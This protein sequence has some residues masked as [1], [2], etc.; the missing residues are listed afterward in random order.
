MYPFWEVPHLT[1]GLIIAMIA[2]FHILPSHLATGAFWFMAYIEGKAIND[3]RP[4]LFAFLKRFSLFILVFCFVIGSLTGVG[5]WFSATVASPRA[6]SGLIHNYVW[7]WA[8][9]WVFFLIE[10]ATIYAYYYTFGKVPPRTHRR[11]GLI[12]AWGAWMSMV[13][14]TGILGFMLSSD[15]WIE[16][17]SFFDGFFNSTYWPQLAFRTAGMIAIASVYAIIVAASLEKGKVRYEVIRKAGAWGLCALAA[18]ALF[19]AWYLNALPDHSKELIFQDVIPPLK[20]MLHV[21]IGAAVAVAV[22]FLLF[23]VVRPQLAC[24]SFG[25]VMM[26]VLLAGIGA[27]EGLREGCRRPYI[28]N[29]YM[30]GNQVVARD[31]EAKKVKGEVEFFQE[32]GLTSRLL[33]FPDQLRIFPEEHLAKAG[34]IIALHQCGNCHTMDQKG[35]RPLPGLLANLGLEDAESIADFLDAL[36]EYPFMP[37]FAAD[38]DEKRATAAYL[39]TLIPAGE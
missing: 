5:I 32:H 26:L 12:Y 24:R 38:E 14:I 8:T 10:I 33:F 16:T 35:I 9:E 11:I 15:N 20:T 25:I 34:R 27:G 2:S 7:G 28:I 21:A 31:L 30:Y 23:G 1:S 22:Y 19:A 4:E 17:G 18:G 3:N 13:I 29:Q 37:P 36:G 39:A 6:I